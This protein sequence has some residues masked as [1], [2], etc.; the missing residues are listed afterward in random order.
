MTNKK[1]NTIY[2]KENRWKKKMKGKERDI[3]KLS[4]SKNINPI[5]DIYKIYNL[6]YLKY[7]S[8]PNDERYIISFSHEENIALVYSEKYS[9]FSNKELKDRFGKGYYFNK[10][11]SELS[12]IEDVSNYKLFTSLPKYNMILQR[13]NKNRLHGNITYKHYYIYNVKFDYLNQYSFY[14][15]YKGHPH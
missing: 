9:K 4:F 5:K 8:N 13:Y 7:K 6:D 12:K 14:T 1:I 3:K 15:P 10:S 11:L 2:F